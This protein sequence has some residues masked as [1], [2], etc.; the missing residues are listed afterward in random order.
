MATASISSLEN[1]SAFIRLRVSL[2][3]TTSWWWK[4]TVPS[5]TNRRVRGLPT[6]CISAAKRDDEVRAAAGQPVLEVDRLLEH[7]QRVLVDVLVPVVLVALERERRQLGQHAL[8]QP[9][10]DQQGQAQRAGTARRPA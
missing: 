2:A 6:S 1:R 10:L 7:G 8:G 4:V 3:P 9:G 5:S